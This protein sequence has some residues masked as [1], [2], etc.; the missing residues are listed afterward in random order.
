MRVATM[1]QFSH[2]YPSFIEKIAHNVHSVYSW[3]FVSGSLS[4]H[5]TETTEY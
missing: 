1:L 5:G 2:S 3:S 4:C